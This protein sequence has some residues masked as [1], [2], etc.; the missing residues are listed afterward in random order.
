MH[1]VQVE[2]ATTSYSDWKRAFDSD[3]IG[4]ERGGVRAY[5]ISRRTDDPDYVVIDLEFDDRERA[6]AFRGALERMWATPQAQGVLGG[7]P[8]ARLIEQVETVAY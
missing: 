8:Q 4:R 2:H 6:V 5:R 3:P 1:I 7:V